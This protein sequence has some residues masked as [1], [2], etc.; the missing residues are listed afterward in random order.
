MCVWPCISE[1]ISSL[2]VM[3][4][5]TLFTCC[6]TSTNFKTNSLSPR[7]LQFP[8]FLSS[9]DFE[10]EHRTL[11]DHHQGQVETITGKTHLKPTWEYFPIHCR[12][13]SLFLY[14]SFSFL[15]FQIFDQNYHSYENECVSIIIIIILKYR[16]RNSKPIVLLPSSCSFIEPTPYEMPFEQNK[17]HQ[18]RRSAHE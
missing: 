5:M 15:V 2:L 12:F 8:L 7:N 3:S 16:R 17:S 6:Q 1:S 14:Y 9:P 18:K 4:A 13:S 10:K 11:D